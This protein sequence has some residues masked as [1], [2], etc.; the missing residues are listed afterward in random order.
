MILSEGEFTNQKKYPQLAGVRARR[1][2]PM[3]LEFSCDGQETLLHT[4]S[5]GGDSFTADLYGSPIEV[6]HQG[7][8]LAD[9]LSAAAG[10]ELELV[11]PASVFKRIIPLP[12]LAGL[13]GLDHTGF[14]DVAPLLLTS[15]A[16]LADLNKRLDSP[17]DMNR[18][19]P[20]IVVRGLDAWAE[21]D[22][23]AYHKDELT[24]RSQAQ[25]ERCA[26]TCTDQQTGQRFGEPLRTLREFRKVED[27]YSS[28]IVFGQYL[29]VDGQGTLAVGDLLAI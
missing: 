27:A 4:V 2:G 20:N 18:F 5:S 14:V 22:I 17:I 26:V 23:Q 3:E 7:S 11:A 15:E 10:T 19:R 9:W 8:A 12:Q 1:T 16:S 21:D 28:G 24:L 13:D 29:S 25:C 6:I